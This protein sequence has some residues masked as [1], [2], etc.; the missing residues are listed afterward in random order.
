MM[1]NKLVRALP[2]SK[3]GWRRSPSSTATT[4]MANRLVR[5]LPDDAWRHRGR[6][7][8]STSRGCCSS[9]SVMYREEDIVKRRKSLLDPRVELRLGEIDRVAPDEQAS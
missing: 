5:A 6:S 8:T 7:F 3:T 2:E 1:A 9:R 4:M